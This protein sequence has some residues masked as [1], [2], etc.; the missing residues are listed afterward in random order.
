MSFPSD[1]QFFPV[2]INGVPVG[3]PAGDVNPAS[4]DIVGNAQFPA[5]YVSYDTNFVYFRLRLNGDPRAKTGFDNFAWGVLINTDG[6]PSTY[7]WVLAVNGQNA[8]LDLIE[9]KIKVPNTFNDPAEGIDGKGTPNY[10]RPIINFDIARVKPTGDGSTF[11]GNEDYFLDFFIPA[12]VLFGTLGITNQTDL[13]FIF[14]SSANNNNFNKDFL[15][16]EGST[17][18]SGFSD[19]VAPQGFNAQAR[20]VLA[21]ALTS[22]PGASVLAGQV[23][24]YTGTLSISNQGKSQA[25]AVLVADVFGLDTVSSLTVSGV[26]QGLSTV[27]LLGRSISWNAGNLAPG[28]TVT[29]TF[30]VQ[31]AFLT[32]GGG[33]RVLNTATGTGFDSLTGQV[34]TAGPATASIA[35]ITAGGVTGTIFNGMT[36]LP[37]AGAAVQ[38]TN[39]LTQVPVIQ[40]SGTA[41]AYGFSNLVPGTY[42]LTVSFDSFVSQ[43]VP[44]TIS[45]GIVTPLDITLRPQPASL[46]GTV[47]DQAGNVL[48]GAVVRVKSPFGAI[49]AETTA[50]AAGQYQLSV[51]AG[52][53]TV[54]AAADGFQSQ[55]RTLQLQPAQSVSASFSLAALPGTVSGVIT[56]NGTGI[57]LPEALVEALNERGQQIASAVSANDGSYTIN[58]LATGNY[59]IRASEA[60]FTTEI[61]GSSVV[62]GQTATVNIG[63]NPAP[64][65]LTGQVTDASTGQP[66]SGAVIRVVTVEGITTATAVTD[67]AGTYVVNSLQPVNYTVTFS[68]AAYASQT[69]G[70]SIAPGTQSVLNIAL[71]QLAG[72]ITG[73]V[74]DLNG[75]P[76]EN[77]VVRTFMNSFVVATLNADQN[78]R[79]DIHGLAPG[80]YMVR[81]E[82]P[83]YQRQLIGAFIEPGETVEVDFALPHQPGTLR[84][85]VTAGAAPVQ[86]AVLVV[87]QTDNSVIGRTITS[88]DGTFV[89]EELA[90]GTYTAA[91]FADGLQ[92]QIKGF[93]ITPDQTT[94][95]SYN[96]EPLPGILS[97][98]VLNASNGLVLADIPV[99][100]R[101]VDTNGL[102]IQSLF[103]DQF[104][105]FTAPNLAPGSYTAILSSTD[106]QTDLVSFLITA[107]QT[108]TVS[109]S[110]IPTPGQISGTVAAADSGTGISG[111]SIRISNYTGTLITTVLT[112]SSGYFRAEGLAPDAYI[113]TASQTGFQ[114]GSVGAIV[115]AGQTATTALSLLPLPGSVS[116][117]IS[118]LVDGTVIQIYD[119]NNLLIN[120]ELVNTGNGTFRFDSLV[121]GAYIVTATPP[122]YAVAK[123]GAFVEAG[124]ESSVSLTLSPLLSVLSGRVTDTAGIPVSTAV[125]RVLDGNETLLGTGHSDENGVYVVD[126]I[127]AGNHFL[128]VTAPGFSTVIIG[129]ATLPGKDLAGVDIRLVPNPGA[130]SGQ[131]TNVSDGNPLP[132]ATVLIR[133]ADISNVLIATATTSLFGNFFVSGLAPGTYTVVAEAE[134]FAAGTSGAIVISDQETAA[135]LALRPLSGIV[136]GTVTDR[137]GTILTGSETQIKMYNEAGL[138]LFAYLADA[139]G[140][141]TTPAL[142]PGR[143][144]LTAS[145]SGFA[146]ASELV[147][148]AAGTTGTVTLVLIPQNALLTGNVINR[149]GSAPVPGSI[150]TLQNAAGQTVDQSVTDLSGNFAIENVTAGVYTL[151]VTSDGFGSTSLGVTL[152]AGQTTAVTVPLDPLP[153]S[154]SGFVIDR[155][156][157]APLAGA[158]IRI[159]DAAGVPVNTVQTDGSGFYLFNNLSSGDY[160]VTAEAAGFSSQNGG[161]PVAPGRNTDYSFALSPLPASLSGT[162]T[163]AAGA[164]PLAGVL[165]EVRQLN[166]YGT[167]LTDTTT[168]AA[169]RY[170]L[171]G[172]PGGN[173]TAVFSLSGFGQQTDAFSAPPGQNTVVDAQLSPTSNDL[174]GTVVTPPTVPV[175]PPPPVADVYDDRNTPVVT[176]PT[177]PSGQFTAD[178]IAAGDYTVVVQKPGLSYSQQAVTIVPGFTPNIVLTPGTPALTV[179]GLVTDE[180]TGN[181]VPGA[182]VQIVNEN[183]TPVERTLTDGTGVILLNSLRPGSYTITVSSELFGSKSAAVSLT[184]GTPASPVTVALN[185]LFGTL[186]GTVTDRNERLL[187]DVF[188]QIFDPAGL[189][190]RSVTTS[191]RGVYTVTNLAPG[192]Y[193]ARFTLE[194]K[195]PAARTLIIAANETTLLNVVLDDDSE[196]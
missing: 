33:S 67:A 122:G 142:A 3:D 17:F 7:E 155:T 104:G 121:P 40:T 144:V 13:Q 169:G 43:T 15:I 134:G 70:V 127:P 103:T 179:T 132:S 81:A 117:V 194:D 192:F 58:S 62:A 106:F 4:T 160:K 72:S 16:P 95:V 12:A 96:L 119:R 181:P 54:I 36:G 148:V 34:I 98:I 75:N 141:F 76:L 133:S 138:L 146:S 195:Q 149:N 42:N 180:S 159:E 125:I 2:T 116:G 64:G 113:V 38:L 74:T 35:V 115:S 5:A 61:A 69:T 26:T 57:P 73:L 131:I 135:S 25:N 163:S 161:A 79:F 177:D 187:S 170:T 172:L 90:P 47:A 18:T 24:S 86:G 107:G 168:D 32:A 110:L 152:R 123:A 112:D 92:T 136:T 60:G 11:G 20:L 23:A 21:K 156:T 114:Q 176:V 82:T 51:P 183:L 45:A 157:S 164:R 143:Y 147:T 89:L 186:T 111:A 175:F 105:A 193:S 108:T 55:V 165:V 162:V 145:A 1:S 83:G 102:V 63:L 39:T 191:S 174:N 140:R 151:T 28:Q 118:P 46:S 130:V 178:G 85:T 30:T 173:Y 99:A 48:P 93:S 109:A 41:G 66:L 124:Q 37:L 190:L 19:P 59:R 71:S 120:E 6:S 126:N 91:V 31:G 50:D 188:V 53:Y 65:T 78:G 150:V 100:V 97:G 129:V 8:S 80:S 128:V 29:L 52:T 84:G 68:E 158:N 137:S 88:S 56:V 154:V 167:V 44:V 185:P 139:D 22:T 10:T 77:A 182:S 14:F 171:S 9:N 27:N 166:T 153:G 101:I 49:I 94:T 189:F 196:E 87:R 184:A